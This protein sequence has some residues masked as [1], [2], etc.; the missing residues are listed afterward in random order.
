[1]SEVE[2]MLL[3]NQTAIVT[4]ANRGLGKAIAE[5]LASEGATVILVGRNLEAAKIVEKEFAEKGWISE[6]VSCDVTKQEQVDELVKHVIETYGS[7]EILVNNAG[8]SK[9]IK[10]NDISMDVWDEILDTNL[11]SVVLVTKAVLPHMIGKK[12]GNIVNIGSG[13]AIRGLPGSSAYS[14]SKAA[15]VCLTQALGD[16]VREHNIRCNVICPG[17]VDT[18]LF[19]KS[20]RREFIL[21]AGGDVFDP[22]TVANGVLFLASDLSKGMSSQILTMRGFNRW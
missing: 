9:E 6:A 22:E 2:N 19:R 7:I 21:K 14:A 16:E 3:E 10:L 18:E 1:M 13:A 11:R 15:V 17:P 5:K 12:N 4:G 20:E 8:I